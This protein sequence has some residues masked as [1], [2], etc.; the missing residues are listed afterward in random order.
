MQKI[1]AT[2]ATGLIGS[3]F[4]EMFEG[5]Y[6]VI[7]MDL[8]T[9][10]DITKVE[11]FAPFFDAHSDAKALIH[12]AAFT[13]T[14]KSALEAGDKNGI[15]YQVNVK[16][17]KNIAEFCANR[18]IYLIHVSTDFVFD[19]AQNTPYLEESPLSPIDWYGETKAQ[20]EKVV[21]NSGASFAIAR[22]SY[23][24]RANFAA[25]PDLIKKN[26]AGLAS[27]SLPPQFSD[28]LI[29]PTFIDDI[30]LAFDKLIE[31]KPSGIFHTVGSSAL[32]P[33]E[34]AQKVAL[35]YGFDPQLVKAGSL[36]KYMQSTAR[37]FARYAAI[38][39][40]QTSIKLGLH[41]A[42]LEEGLAII[43]KQQSL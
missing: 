26:R 16:G 9:G 38:S 1:L 32:S 22:L 13:D 29:T 17:T 20:A 11:T 27:Q 41:F 5:K 35:A 33:F 12:L 6:T 31:Q 7:N 23:P 40:I 18:G 21:Q 15:C 39:N 10:V 30:A 34:L 2:G 25:K 14:T 28:T 4:V 43:K 19:G 42:S 3:R 8:T 37:P 36:T 24:Y